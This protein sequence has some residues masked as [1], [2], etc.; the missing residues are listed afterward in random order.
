MQFFRS[1]SRKRSSEVTVSWTRGF[2][3]TSSPDQ[4]DWA[5][6]PHGRILIGPSGQLPH[7]RKNPQDLAIKTRTPPRHIR[8]GLL[9]S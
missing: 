7:T 8:L 3:N 5:E 6:D 2:L 9:L 4:L 1:S